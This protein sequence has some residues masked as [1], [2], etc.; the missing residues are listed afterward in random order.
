M[1]TETQ[2]G[3]DTGAPSTDAHVNDDGPSDEEEDPTIREAHVIKNRQAAAV[4][5][6]SSDEGEETTPIEFS[7]PEDETNPEEADINSDEEELEVSSTV[8]SG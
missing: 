3:V 2:P 8:K 1:N 7:F 5:D 4:A 6:Y